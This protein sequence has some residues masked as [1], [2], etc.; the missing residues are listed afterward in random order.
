MSTSTPHM[1]DVRDML[2]VHESF[3]REFGNAPAL[4]RGVA[5]GD[6]RRAKTVADHLALMEEFL[7][8]HHHGEDVLLWPKLLDRADGELDDVVAEMEHDHVAIDALL[9]KATSLRERWSANADPG[10]GEEFASVVAQLGA[11]LTAHLATEETK[12]LPLVPRYITVEEWHELGDHAITKLPKSKL[13]IIFGML[14]SLADRDVVQLMLDSAPLVPR[15]LMPVVGPLAYRAHI[16][17]VYGTE[18]AAA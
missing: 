15:L 13:P 4:V 8:L 12:V 16:K 7:H 11:R 10:V 1:A 3:R 2:V 14:A 6:I 18:K 17:K 9:A 5:E